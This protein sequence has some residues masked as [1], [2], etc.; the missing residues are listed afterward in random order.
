MKHLGLKV[1]STTR[2]PEKE[3]YLKANGAD[4]VIIDNGNIKEQVK[5]LFPNGVDKVLE[6][7][8]TRTLKDS[9]KCIKPRGMVCMTGILGSEWTM[10]EFTP[11]GDIRGYLDL[12]MRLS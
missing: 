2:K 12:T 10:K 6:L 5:N 7:I 1:I 11:M 9:L 8:G 3:E 4:L